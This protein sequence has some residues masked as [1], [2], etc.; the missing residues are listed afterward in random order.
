M[1]ALSV[2]APWW[3]YIVRGYKD[4]ENR[5]WYSDYRGPVWIHASKWWNGSDVQYEIEGIHAAMIEPGI[6]IPPRLSDL[7]PYGGCIVGSAEIVGCVDRH[8]SRWFMGDYG[9]VLRNAVPLE[10]PIPVKG[11][12]GFFDV[13]KSLVGGVA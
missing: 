6:T 5:D 8:N 10:V 3:W 1:K 2:R 13:P 11:S 9:F 12:L 4:I 7:Q